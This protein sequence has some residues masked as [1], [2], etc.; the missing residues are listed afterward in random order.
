MEVHI[1]AAPNLGCMPEVTLQLTMTF[2]RVPAA[3]Y[4][5]GGEV[6]FPEA[7]QYLYFPDVSPLLSSLT[8]YVFL[9]SSRP[10]SEIE[11]KFCLES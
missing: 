5:F 4:P 3:R 8:G 2:R 7:L 9:S 1:L 10:S 11:I 6:S